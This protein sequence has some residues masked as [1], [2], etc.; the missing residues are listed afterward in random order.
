MAVYGVDFLRS[1]LVRKRERGLLRYR[2]YDQKNKVR[3]FGISTPP[4]LLGLQEIMGWCAK[5]VDTLSDRLTFRGFREEDDVF[6][7]NQI[8]LLNDRDRLCSSAILGALIVS[9]SF[10][11]ISRDETGY[12]RLQVID[13]T[14]ATG[15][16]NQVT[17]LLD[18]GY[19]VL[20]R[21][22]IGK[23]IVEAY[24]LPGQTIIY[25]DGKQMEIYQSTARYPLLVPVIF[26]PDAKRPF[27]HSRI[28]RACM[29]HAD[30]A[31]R[32]AKRAEVTA[33]FYS[34]PQKYV[35]GTDPGLQM[36]AWSAA[37][38]AML[39]LSKGEDGDLPKFGQF[40]QASMEPHIAQLRMEAALFAGETGLTLDDLGFA[41]DNPSSS[42]AIKAA[43]ENLRLTARRSQAIFG[44][45]FRNACYLAACERD[46]FA[47]NRQAFYTIRPIWAPVFEPDTQ[48]LAAIGDGAYKLNNAVPGYM[49]EIAMDSLT[50]LERA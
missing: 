1:K 21:D 44:S 13:G 42:E 11:Y 41:T 5:A 35:V 23:P 33:E 31:A 18:E 14:D 6:D 48:A 17:G 29:S 10:V 34:F 22:K 24:F 2:Y 15:I 40:A 32:T 28:S 20:E 43:H 49:D 12:P 45:A 27:G 37:M 25:R 19:A 30:S 46:E 36:E 8:L 16:I 26:R 38:S 3:D 7:L 50:G 47:Y 4:S 39:N 9:C